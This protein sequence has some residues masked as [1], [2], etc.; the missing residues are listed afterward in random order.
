MGKK[1]PKVEVVTVERQIVLT[2]KRC[3]QCGRRFMGTKRQK[4]CSKRCSNVA[5]YWR[6]PQAYRESRIKSY[7]KQKEREAEA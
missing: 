7:H 1:K 6:N 2:E 4:Y 5:A 3:P